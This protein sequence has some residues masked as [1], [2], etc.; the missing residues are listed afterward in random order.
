MNTYL[1]NFFYQL[2]LMT[3]QQ[4]PISFTMVA[5]FS[6]VSKVLTT[7]QL[8]WDLSIGPRINKEID[9]HGNQCWVGYVK[10]LTKS[11]EVDTTRGVGHQADKHGGLDGIDDGYQL[12]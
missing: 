1:A 2:K 6:K 3:K 9:L 8:L 5:S 11:Q 7:I 4:N 12:R 10:S